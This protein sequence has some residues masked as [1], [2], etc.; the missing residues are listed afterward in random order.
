[1]AY[2]IVRY[3]TPWCIIN[4][5]WPFLFIFGAATLIIG[6]KYKN[7]LYNSSAILLSVS[8]GSTVWLN[9]FHCTTDTEPYVY[10]QTYND[11]YK[12]TDPLLKLAHQD[13]IFYQLTGHIIRASPYP[14]PWILDD[15]P[16]V[17]YY[18]HDNSPP[19]FDADFLLVQEDRV[20]EVQAKLH[21]SYYTEPLR[22]RPYQDTSKLYLNA[23]IFKGFFSGRSPDFVGKESGQGTSA[24]Q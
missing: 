3:K 4:I 7:V 21:D 13:P 5:I 11:I 9:Y 24:P 22:I 1:M 20:Q 8:L 17:G 12:L 23:R 14:L 15:F 16:K 6:P 19:Q 10:V 18:E 2:S